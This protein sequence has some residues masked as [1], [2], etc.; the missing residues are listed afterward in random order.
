MKVVKL[1]TF[2]LKQHSIL[3]EAWLQKAITDDPALLGLGDLVVRDKERVQ[4]SGGRIDLVLQDSESGTRYEVEIQLGTTDETHIVR[5]IEYWDIERT[6][7]PQY[8]HKAVLIAENVTSRFL[9][10]LRLFNGVVPL[11]VLQLS[12][13]E[14]V[15]GIG[16]HFTRVLDE[17]PRGLVDEDEAVYEPATL[18][19]WERIGTPQTVQLARDLLALCKPLD[20]SLELKPNKHYIG[21]QRQGVAFNF[22][23]FRPQKVGI[24]ISLKMPRTEEVD[25]QLEESGLELLEYARSGAYRIKIGREG[26]A[27]HGDLLSELLKQAFNSRS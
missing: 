6:R 19:D 7:Y 15:D 3:N 13:I 20:A 23:T 14:T 27:S 1:K 22:V 21:L 11:I 18:Q 24:K 16:L 5:T 10:V 9:N 17:M 26:I 12:A 4:P 25:R 2:S 8:D